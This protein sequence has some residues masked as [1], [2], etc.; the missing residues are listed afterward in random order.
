MDAEKQLSELQTR[1]SNLHKRVEKLREKVD[2][3]TAAATLDMIGKV[4]QLDTMVAA[5]LRDAEEVTSEKGADIETTNELYLVTTSKLTSLE[6][7]I[8]ALS[9]G[10]PTTVSAILDA[11]VNLGKKR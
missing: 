5:L 4:D 9:L 11:L 8:E 10:N 3:L 2:G 7:E 1:A 6:Q